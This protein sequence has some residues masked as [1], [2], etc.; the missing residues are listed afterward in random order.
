MADLK[1]LSVSDIAE[2]LG[3]S[4]RSAHRI[5][6]ECLHV[7]V[8]GG[9]RVPRPALENYLAKCQEVPWENYSS[10]ASRSTVISDGKTG[11]GS[12]SRYVRKTAKLLKQGYEMP[13]WVR[14]GYPRTTP[15]GP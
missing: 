7:R 2:L 15:K 5:A 11:N 1:Y 9:I 14:I 13:S 10:A 8:P 12:K 6:H 4:K 3:V